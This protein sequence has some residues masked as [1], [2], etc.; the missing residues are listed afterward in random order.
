VSDEEFMRVALREAEAALAHDDVPVGAVV[1]RD[2]AIV[3]S[4]KNERELRGDP[5][6]HAEML[7]LQEAARSLGTWRLSGTT[8]YVTLEPCPMCAGA[9]VHSRIDRLVYG[10][11]DPKAGAALSLYNV[12]QDPRLNHHVDITTGVLAEESAQLLQEF[13]LGKRL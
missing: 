4:A 9:T 7:A 8:L 10:A 11:I 1:V 6:A 5:T 13:F 12:P 2:G 3:A